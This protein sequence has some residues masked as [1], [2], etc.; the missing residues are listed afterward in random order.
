MTFCPN[1]FRREVQKLEEVL[2]PIFAMY[3]LRGKEG[4]AFGDFTARVGFDAIRK[5]SKGY[6]AADV[7]AALPKVAIQADVWEA[8]QQ[9]AE[10]EGKSPAHLA[11]VALQQYLSSHA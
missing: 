10:R 8:L 7:E 9:L 6:I 5:Y 4:E 11:S 3:K 1:D 2:E